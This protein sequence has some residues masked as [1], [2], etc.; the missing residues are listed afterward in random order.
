M[1]LKSVIL[2]SAC[3]VLVC[4]LPSLAQQKGQWVPGQFGLN[5]GVIPDPGITYANLAVNYSADR[6]NNSSGDR[7]LTNVTGTY[8]FW[9][10][11]NIIYYVPEHKFLGG[12]FMPYI[13]INY[14]TGS[15]VADLPPLL[16]GS[17]SGI[18][19]SGGGSGLADT[20]V[21]PV[22][23]GWHFGKRVDFNAGYSFTAPTGRYSAGASDNVGS[24]YWGNDITSGTTLYITKNHGTTANLATA[25]EIHGQKT[26]ASRPSGQF[27]KITPGQAFTQ[28]WGIGQVLPLKKDMSQ[29]AQLGLVGYDQWQVSGNGGNYLLAGTPIAASRVPYYSVH[30]IGV[31]ANYILP[32]K[33]LAFFFKYYDEYSAKARPQGRTIVFGF[34]WT[35]KIPRTQPAKP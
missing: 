7:I 10:D 22:N 28:E 8:S 12:Y 23:M 1:Q 32:A 9:A 4:A 17:T 27:S 33:D 16:P 13:A 20:Y 31:Q 34:S 11:E 30:G 5:A 19:L 6:L 21:Q 26:I 3:L 24:G 14:A 15:L 2:I 35:L 29:L 25:W 18:S